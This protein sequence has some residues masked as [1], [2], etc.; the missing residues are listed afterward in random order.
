AGK[1]ASATRLTAAGSGINGGTLG[2]TG[3]AETH[4]LTTAEMPVHN[5]GVSDPNHVHSINDPSHSHTLNE[6]NFGLGGT[7]G[8]S[9]MQASGSASSTNAQFTGISL[10]AAATGITINNAGSGGAHTV[11]QPTIV[12]NYIIAF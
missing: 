5:H 3:G 11:T 4:T 1:E 9:V 6:G 2:A 7:G 10:N 12:L 8:G